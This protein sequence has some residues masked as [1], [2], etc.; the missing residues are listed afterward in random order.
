MKPVK[1]WKITTEVVGLPIPAEDMLEPALEPAA[2]AA[3]A[4]AAE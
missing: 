1:V 4:P 3:A 2:E